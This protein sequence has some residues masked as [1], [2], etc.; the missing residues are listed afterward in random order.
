MLAAAEQFRVLPSSDSFQFGRVSEQCVSCR[1]DYSLS[2][3]FYRGCF[4]YEYIQFNMLISSMCVIDVVPNPP[5][6]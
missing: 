1:V 3:P 5:L 4:R 2:L 6:C